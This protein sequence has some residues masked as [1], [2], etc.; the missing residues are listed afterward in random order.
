MI[1]ED[2][3]PNAAT[4]N[5]VI[6]ALVE[7]KSD[8]ESQN[9]DPL[10]NALSVYKV[11]KSK[12]APRGVAP[13]RQTYN[14]LVRAFSADLRPG[15]AES[16]LNAMRKDG[17]VP[18]VDL[19]TLTVRSYERCGN[20][21]KALRM[22]ESMREVGYDFY[23]V[24]VLNEAFKNG[25]KILNRVGKGFSSEGNNEGTGQGELD[26]DEQEAWGRRSALRKL[27]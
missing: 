8:A 24:K 21:M 15:Y 25:V 27:K 17:F 7:G 4:F 11:M 26:F 10:E 2:L 3:S 19:Y 13:N 14:L 23:E 18:D 16:L 9:D 12:H 5:T 6:A 20:P 22:M 1:S